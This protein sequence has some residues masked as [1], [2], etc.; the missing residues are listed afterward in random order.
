MSKYY[1]TKFGSIIAK[2]PGTKQGQVILKP[3]QRIPDGLIPKDHMEQHLK[4][5]FARLSG[6]PDMFHELQG[7]AAPIMGRDGKLREPG[8]K[9]P[10]YDLTPSSLAKK[11]LAQLNEIVKKKDP[12]EDLFS[13]KSQ[14]IAFLT[15]DLDI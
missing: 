10:T 7:N 5:G 9:A 4:S 2:K 11:S 15:S 6:A 14:A 8:D 1:V 12:S 3:G 13:N